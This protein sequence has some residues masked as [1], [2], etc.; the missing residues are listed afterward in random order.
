MSRRQSS[1]LTSLIVEPLSLSSLQSVVCC[2][3]HVI[4]DIGTN[5]GGSFELS[6][7]SSVVVVLF[8]RLIDV[9]KLTSGGGD[10]DAPVKLELLSVVFV[11]GCSTLLLVFEVSVRVVCCIMRIDYPGGLHRAHASSHDCY[12][13]LSL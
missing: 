12:S 7:S 3:C 8:D 4:S 9:D 2:G 1:L 5:T 6:L 10:S 13:V 11:D